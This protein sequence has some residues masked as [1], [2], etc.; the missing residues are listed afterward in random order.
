M[1][2]YYNDKADLTDLNDAGV[3][4]TIKHHGPSHLWAAMSIGICHVGMPGNSTYH[5][6][7]LIDSI[8]PE[9]Y[10]KA[11]DIAPVALRGYQQL[12]SKEKLATMTPDN[13]WPLVLSDAVCD[14]LGYPWDGKI[15]GL[16]FTLFD[17]PMLHIIPDDREEELLMSLNRAMYLLN[18]Y[19]AASSLK[20]REYLNYPYEIDPYWV[21]TVVQ[22]ANLDR[23]RNG[24]EHF[25]KDLKEWFPHYF[26]LS[27]KAYGGTDYKKGYN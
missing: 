19:L 11:I 18:S 23:K 25:S 15:Q 10:A 4:K 20:M 1:K 26:H 5:T 16:N 14:I 2:D 12:F 6:Q 7:D 13:S 8:R 3:R 27:R 24:N 22:M 17:N 21:T 9:L